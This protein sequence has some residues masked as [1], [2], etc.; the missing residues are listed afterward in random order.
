MDI[1]KNSATIESA[2]IHEIIFFL[3]SKKVGSG[4]FVL[5]GLIAREYAGPSTCIS[6][7]IAGG[8]AL[9]SGC[10][11]AELSGRIPS[12]GSS[13]AYV[14]AA[15]GEL[16]AVIAAACLSLEYLVSGSA[17]A[18]SWGD[19]MVV[20]LK[21][22]F[23]MRQLVLNLLEPGFGFNTMAFL[24][25]V[26]SLALLL[27]GVKESKNVTNIF[28]TT[29]VILVLYMIFGGAF[30]F[31]MDNLKPFFPPKFGVGGMMRGATSSFF[32]YIGYDEVCCVAGE[33]IQPQ[34]NMPKAV[35]LTI[36]IVTFL[37]VFASVS[38]VGMQPYFDISSTSGFPEGKSICHFLNFLFILL[39][40]IYYFP[41]LLESFSIQ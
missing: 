29:K 30:Y 31:R 19:K 13:Y 21:S 38:L 27:K 3:L 33:A 28:T 16:P 9:L 22:E 39:F 5:S 37:T 41:I 15:M 23:H 35:M 36:A 2:I 20:W 1:K 7:V 32:G 11:Y 34:K 24:V 18:R 14:Y 25:S 12:S 10:C 8:A 26:V 4:I 17:V 40:I 6:W